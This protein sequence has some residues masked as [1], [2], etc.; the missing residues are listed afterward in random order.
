MSDNAKDEVD[1]ARTDSRG[2]G[3]RLVDGVNLVS[4]VTT[5]VRKGKGKEREK[6]VS[7][8]V[9]E[10]TISRELD[11]ARTSLLQLRTGCSPLGMVMRTTCEYCPVQ[12]T[13]RKLADSEGR[14][15]EWM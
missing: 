7:V 5:C 11:P 14:P 1:Q 4:D 12:R 2:E 10:M 15:W 6:S 8:R 9:E 3:E 13:V